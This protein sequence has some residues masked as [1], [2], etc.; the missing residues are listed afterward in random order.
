MHFHFDSRPIPLESALDV[1]ESMF[2]NSPPSTEFLQGLNLQQLQ[3]SSDLLSD[4][5]ARGGIC[6]YGAGTLGRQALSI[7]RRYGLPVKKIIDQRANHELLTLDGL[8]VSPPANLSV[9]DVVAVCVA[10]E[11]SGIVESLSLV[12]A[13]G[14]RLNRYPHML[15]C[16]NHPA[17][18]YIPDLP[19]NLSRDYE[20]GSPLFDSESLDT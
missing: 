8:P 3:Y 9:G 14:I 16:E 19:D 11:E 4:V 7:A 17:T 2:R 13:R 20:F 5:K 6:L 18:R 10:G 15:V 12:G 1:A